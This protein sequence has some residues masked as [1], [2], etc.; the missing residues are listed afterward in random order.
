MNS[1]EFE[2]LC[3]ALERGELGPGHDLDRVGNAS[4]IGLYELGLY[5]PALEAAYRRKCRD[6]T[7]LL[8]R[9]RTLEEQ[10]EK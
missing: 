1:L 2:R 7:V 5:L 4:R 8:A 9:I 3:G 6:I 10:Q